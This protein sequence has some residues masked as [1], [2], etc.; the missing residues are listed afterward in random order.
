MSGTD[1]IKIAEIDSTFNFGG[2]EKYRYTFFSEIERY[3][4]IILVPVS[5]NWTVSDLGIYPYQ[6]LDYSPDSFNVKVPLAVSVENELY[7]VE[8]E[9]YD[10]SSRLAY[11][12]NSYTFTYNKKF[13]PL[14]K[15]IFVDPS[16]I[17][18]N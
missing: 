16:G 13:L 7:E 2:N 10:E 4:T 8:V 1:K 3:G 12:R 18:I 5:G 17:T 14:K 9:L 15:Q 6:N 11:G